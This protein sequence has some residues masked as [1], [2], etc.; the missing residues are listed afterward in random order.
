MMANRMNY[1]KFP[2]QPDLFILE[3][4]VNDFHGQDHVISLDHK[5][6]LFFDGFQKFV[7]CA[8]SV[9]YR[10]LTDFPDTA[11]M[12]LEFR[13]A[14][15]HRKTAQFFHMG[16]AQHYQVPV[17]SYA[18]ALWPDYLRLLDVLR[19]YNYFVP[20]TMVDQ[21]QLDFPFPH[22][23]EPCRLEDITDQFR[24]DGC[25]SLCDLMRW[26]KLLPWELKCNSN[27][28]EVQKC[29]VPFF[30]HD[31]VHP[32]VVGH[33]IANDLIVNVIAQV[34]LDTCEGRV[35]TPHIMPIGGWIAAPSRSDFLY[36]VELRARSDFV[37]V[38]DAASIF[39]DTG[40]LLPNKNTDGFELT[41]D[42]IGRKGWIATNPLGGE[43]I[44]FTIDLPLMDCYA[45]YISVLKSYE[46][47]GTFSLVVDDVTLNTTAAPIDIDCLWNPLIS[48]PV[49]IQI[50]SDDTVQCT[51]NCKITITTHPEI[52][53][54][55]GNLIKIV[56]LLVRRCI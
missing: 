6:D 40:Q 27:L 50:T 17:V 3:F 20:N 23:C 18:D 35:F 38:Q 52:P 47:V 39:A 12:F 7:D 21:L 42:R 36:G 45:I 33:R 44:T 37:L 43:S 41:L 54:R 22:G 51:G 31:D 30:S 4:G 9:I 16:V 19:P 10:I 49:D 2:A 5:T 26:S 25:V 48:I 46:T 29:H 14:R 28:V 53:G 1:L 56:S 32:S 13:T 11:V 34:A 24:H 15:P 55:N 8:E